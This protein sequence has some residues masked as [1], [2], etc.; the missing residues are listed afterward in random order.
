MKTNFQAFSAEIP[1]KPHVGRVIELFTTEYMFDHD[2][3]KNA[4]NKEKFVKLKSLNYNT[5]DALP[6]P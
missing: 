3:L 1:N 6:Y 2:M 4:K 5:N